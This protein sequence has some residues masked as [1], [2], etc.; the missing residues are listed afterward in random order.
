MLFTKCTPSELLNKFLNHFYK[1][2][3]GL[4]KHMVKLIYLCSCSLRTRSHECQLA[5][6]PHPNCGG[7]YAKSSQTHSNILS[8]FSLFLRLPLSPPT[9][10]GKFLPNFDRKKKDFNLCKMIFHGKW[11]WER[12][13][14]ASFEDFFFLNR[15]IF[16]ISS[17]R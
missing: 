17:S 7:L 14:F 12:P 2:H 10:L 9:R 3:L 5:H 8:G 4:S 1:L 15:Q 6:F 16:I 11:S 13:K